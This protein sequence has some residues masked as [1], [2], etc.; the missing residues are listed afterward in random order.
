MKQY[1][2]VFAFFFGLQTMWEIFAIN[3]RA[4]WCKECVIGS[5]KYFLLY[6]TGNI[7]NSAGLLLILWAIC[8]I[9]LPK[10]KSKIW[11]TLIPATITTFIFIWIERNDLRDIPFAIIEIL[12]TLPVVFNKQFKIP[13]LIYK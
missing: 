11:I 6:N 4:L 9:I 1:K 12:I 7:N 2:I 3:H 10:I 13:L 8:S 5:W